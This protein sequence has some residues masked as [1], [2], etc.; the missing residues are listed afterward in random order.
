MP[1]SARW[2]VSFAGTS[3]YLRASIGTTF[4]WMSRC[5]KNTNRQN[6]AP[7]V[8]VALA[9]LDTFIE[10]TWLAHRTLRA[11]NRP[12][13]NEPSRDAVHERPWTRIAACAKA[14]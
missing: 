7:E 8:V 12:I 9:A 10:K 14:R 1:P 11:S 2:N 4:T 5:G 6:N 3:A 13:L